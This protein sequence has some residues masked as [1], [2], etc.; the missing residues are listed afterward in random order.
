KFAYEDWTRDGFNTKILEAEQRIPDLVKEWEALSAKEPERAAK[1]K[2]PVQLLKEWDCV[3]TVD[4][5]PM[6]LFADT[7]DRVLK[8]VAKRDPPNRPRVGALEPPLADRTKPHGTWKV[9]WGETNRLQRVHASQIDMQGHG[10]FNDSRPSL[11]VA[12]APGPLGVVFNFY[13]RP[14]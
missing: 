2:E 10:Q 7:Y 6:T 4:S 5:V 9:T 8:M 13:T 11:P 12:G 3:S 14:Q 1:V